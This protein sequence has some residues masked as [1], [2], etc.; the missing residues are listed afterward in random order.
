[1]I[2]VCFGLWLT[3]KLNLLLK[4]DC[5]GFGFVA[6]N[7]VDS[8]LEALVGYQVA[9]NIRI[10]GGDRG[11]YAS[12]GTNDIAVHGWLHGPMLGTVFSF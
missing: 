3:P 1:M 11:R 10:Y 8:V 12:G 6:Y 4:A 5:G 9:K 2:G 7:N